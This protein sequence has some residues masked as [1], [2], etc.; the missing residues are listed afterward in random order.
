M[1]ADA[2]SVF[3]AALALSADDRADLAER[4]MLT[5]DQQRQAQLEAAWDAEINRRLDEIDSGAVKLIPGD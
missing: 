5:L 1:T 3:D 2:K 4:L